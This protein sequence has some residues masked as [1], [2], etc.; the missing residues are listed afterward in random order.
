[1][2]LF[3]HNYL[4]EA[5]IDDIDIKPFVEAMAYDDL[6]RLDQDSLREFC[7]SPTAKA[8]L[9][10]QVLQ[11]GTLMRLSKQDDR[12]RRIK[13]CAYQLAK[14][15]KNTNWK[16]MIYH[17][18]EWRKYRD[19]VMKQYG[20]RAEKIADISQREYIKKSQKTK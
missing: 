6:S 3:G 8:L 7:E 17:R 20:K 13:L 1:M 11:K 12:K 14:A 5:T 19:L 15:D 16:K 4:A 18:S 10:K 2:V 9:E